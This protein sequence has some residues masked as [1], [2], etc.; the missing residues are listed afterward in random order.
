MDCRIQNFG[1]VWK[2]P[3]E[4]LQKAERLVGSIVRHSA[5]QTVESSALQQ[6]FVGSSSKRCF[7][8]RQRF[9]TVTTL[10]ECNG[11]FQTASGWCSGL[12]LTE[13]RRSTAER[14]H[15]HAR[16][17]LQHRPIINGRVW[18]P[19]HDVSSCESQRRS[20]GSPRMRLAEHGSA[21]KE[22][23]RRREDACPLCRG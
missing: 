15:E 22:K 1:I 2:F 19:V 7:Q 9:S 16:K 8:Q 14:A 21:S 20:L 18:R 11:T 10:G 6:V 13:S 17:Q 3:A 12:D 5:M 23:G 4:H